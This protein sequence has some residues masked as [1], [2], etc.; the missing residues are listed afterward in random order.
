MPHSHLQKVTIY[1]LPGK[2]VFP[3]RAGYSLAT[4]DVLDARESNLHR[5]VEQMPGILWTTD[6]DLNITLALGNG[7][8]RLNPTVQHYEGMCLSE[9][10]GEDGVHAPILDAHYSALDGQPQSLEINM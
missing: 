3:K 8:A 9:F 4:E 7:L 5:I 6:L 1:P 10:F 2:P